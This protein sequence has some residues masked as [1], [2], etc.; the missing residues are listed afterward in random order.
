MPD[1]PET[2]ELLFRMLDELSAYLRECPYYSGLA[3]FDGCYKL[4]LTAKY[5]DIPRTYREL[6]AWITQHEGIT[7]PEL[8]E[9]VRQQ[10][11]SL[12]EQVRGK[13]DFPIATPRSLEEPASPAK[14][15]RLEGD[16]QPTDELPDLVTLDQ[17]AALA[18]RTVDGIRHYRRTGMPK[19][20]VKGTK[21]KPNEYLW[22]EMRPWLETTFGRKIP[23]V[24]VLRFRTSPKK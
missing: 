23:E 11:R 6:R 13:L 20:F 24:S 22:S 15:V 19:P 16:S 1:L 18:N 14:T 3:S 17:A 21:G 10:V 4:I 5:L 2:Q 8:W 12:L 7:V 9:E